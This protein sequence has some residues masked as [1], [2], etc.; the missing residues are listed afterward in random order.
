MIKLLSSR[1]SKG[2]HVAAFIALVLFPSG[3]KDLGGVAP[4][5]AVQVIAVA[6][7]NTDTY[8][9]PT[10]GGDE[11]GAVIT[12]QAQHYRLSE[13]RRDSSTN[14]ISVYIYQPQAGYT[15]SD[16][17]ELEVHF[18]NTGAP[19]STHATKVGFSFTVTN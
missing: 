6:L 17:A 12:R 3:C 15:G 5:A 19:E 14:F 11:E 8:Q 2:T 9:Y 4:P 18:N 7:R 13:V 16:S 10:V 1:L